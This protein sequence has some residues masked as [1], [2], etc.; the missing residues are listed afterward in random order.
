MNNK[1]NINDLVN[2]DCVYHARSG[3]SVKD[4]VCG[5]DVNPDTAFGGRDHGGQTYFFC[6]Q[7]CLEEFRTE[8][9]KYL[10]RSQD[11]RA[12]EVAPPDERSQ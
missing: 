3:R 8:P 7:H 1:E 5:M 9:A 4:P 10:T 2:D 6:S 12:R 11:Q